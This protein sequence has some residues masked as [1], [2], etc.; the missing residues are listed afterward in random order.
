MAYASQSDIEARYPGE[1]AQA[2]PRD[3]SGA[4]DDD[5]VALAC[6]WAAATA[7]RYLRAIGWPVPLDDPPDWLVD[8][9]ADMALYMATPTA[10]ASQADFKDRL[11]RYQAAFAQLDAI[12]SGRLVPEPPSSGGAPVEVMVTANTR[13]FGAGVL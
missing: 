5:A 8:L 9:T 6:E 2:G 10:I 4:L 1:L 3:A 12:A 7:D 11:T 13:Q